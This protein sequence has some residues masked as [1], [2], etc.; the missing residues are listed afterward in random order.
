MR[1]PRWTYSLKWRIVASYSLIL[2]TGGVSTAIIGIRVTGRALLQQAQ[3]QVD[4]GLS[5]AR[6]IH[7]NRLTELRQCVEL[8]ATSRRVR[9]ALTDNEPAAARDFVRSMQRAR[10]LD[11][12]SIADA[13]GRVGFR[14]TG[15]GIT[16]DTVADLTPIAAARWRACRGHRT[17]G[18]H[19]TR[20]GRPRSGRA[21]LH[22]A[23]GTL[24]N[25]SAAQEGR[26]GRLGPARR[27]TGEGPGGPGRGRS[28][29]G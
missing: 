11:F 24:P 12:L 7:L 6:T 20:A 29:H 27:G 25:R 23:G 17:A 22:R 13:A 9:R 14:T 5:H 19:S 1:F 28:L 3:H 18:E 16:G 10:G 21:D 4:T 26:G 8:L 15:T 2:I